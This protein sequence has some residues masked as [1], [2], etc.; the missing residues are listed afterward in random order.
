[1]NRKTL[2]TGI[3]LLFIGSILSPIVSGVTVE[4][5]KDDIFLD[6]LSY[7]YSNPLKTSNRKTVDYSRVNAEYQ[8][9]I[10]LSTYIQ[11]PPSNPL[12]DLLIVHGRW[13]HMTTTTQG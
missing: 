11:E 13:H 9:M 1:M 8:V 2:A 4:E 7:V 5:S 10:E 6:D 12:V 3:L